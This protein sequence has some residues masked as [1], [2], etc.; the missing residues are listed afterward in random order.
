MN[1]R[2]VEFR[3]GG[4][5]IIGLSFWMRSLVIHMTYDLCWSSHS[6]HVCVTDVATAAQ[7]KWLNH[8]ESTW[9][10]SNAHSLHWSKNSTSRHWVIIGIIHVRFTKQLRWWHKIQPDIRITLYVQIWTDLLVLYIGI[11]CEGR[12]VVFVHTARFPSCN[13]PLL[14]PLT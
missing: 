9:H 5:L 13:G 14:W 12:R 1:I 10:T 3:I 4:I 7:K 6:N 2:E 8:V 11:N